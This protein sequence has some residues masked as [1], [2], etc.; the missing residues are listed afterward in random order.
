MD[1][2]PDEIFARILNRV[3]IKH[4]VR[5]SIVSKRWDAAC[6]YLIRT[7]E[8]LIIGIDS[9]GPY[10]NEWW[11]WD[12]R[13]QNPKLAFV[14]LDVVYLTDAA[15]TSLAQLQHLTDV[16]VFACQNLTTAGVLTLLRGSSRN[17]IRKLSVFKTNV[18]EDQVTSEIRLM[19][20]E[21]GTTFD[22]CHVRSS[23]VYEI[24]I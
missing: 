11:E 17:V 6:R 21:R 3:P 15:L 12:I 24:H 18:D 8:S 1:D 7:R 19:C 4:V 9:N 2:L 23:F 5:C 14:Y 22:A 20:E 10:R 13:Y 16:E